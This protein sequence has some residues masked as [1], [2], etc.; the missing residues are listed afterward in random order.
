MNTIH[1][2][3]WQKVWRKLVK[4]LKSQ[5]LHLKIRP[6]LT[7]NGTKRRFCIIPMRCILVNMFS[8]SKR[9]LSGISIHKNTSHNMITS[10]VHVE[11]VCESTSCCLLFYPILNAFTIQHLT[12]IFVWVDVTDVN[13]YC[14]AGERQKELQSDNWKTINRFAVFTFKNGSFECVIH[15]CNATLCHEIAWANGIE[16]KEYTNIWIQLNEQSQCFSEGK[17]KHEAH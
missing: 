16:G 2:N 1:I 9:F 6:C 12:L 7:W 5:F 11:T 3:I 10:L 4:S 8:K 13:I 17:L 15:T 14:I